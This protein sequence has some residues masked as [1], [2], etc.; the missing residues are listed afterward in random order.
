MVGRNDL[1]GVVFCGGKGIR[2]RP[3]T[4]YFQKTMVP[5][6][7][8]QKPLLEY[9]IRLMKK[10]KIR[11]IVLLVNYKAHQIVKYFE[12]GSR[13][14]VNISYTYDKPKLGGTGGALLNAYLEGA[15]STG[16][17]LL[18]YYGDILS[19]IDL[20]DMLRQHHE[21]EA[22]VTVALSK[23]YNVPVGVAEV[24]ENGRIRCFVEKPTLKKPVS[25]GVLAMEG[26]VLDDVREL[27]RG[28]ASLDIMTDLVPHLAEE[29][30][31]VWAYF[32]D[33]FWCD[34]GSIER[35]EKLRS[36]TIEKHLSRLME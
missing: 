1:K 21:K 10:H 36:E 14:D 24:A 13:F 7:L 17:K 35:Y 32:T 2:L 12:D 4:Y 5:V 34:L 16:E 27:M 33:A 25:I 28:K 20:T 18:L 9:V 11:D 3:L 22:T 26:E 29:G 8:K 6:G 30:E 23:E 15:L 31:A 19:N